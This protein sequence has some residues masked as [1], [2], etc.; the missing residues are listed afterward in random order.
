MEALGALDTAGADALGDE[1][2]DDAKEPWGAVAGVAA[3][4]SAETDPT[5]AATARASTT[6]RLAIF[7]AVYLRYLEN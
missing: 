5:T 6:S 1:A 3:V 2:E 7:T 4:A